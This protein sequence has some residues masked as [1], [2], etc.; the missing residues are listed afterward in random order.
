MSEIER[1]KR[2]I[3]DIREQ[4]RRDHNKMLEDKRTRYAQQP[5][6]MVSCVD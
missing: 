4:L 3:E 1:C 6:E 2:D 5:D